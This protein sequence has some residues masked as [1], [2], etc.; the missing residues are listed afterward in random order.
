MHS[1][2]EAVSELRAFGADA[3][4]GPVTL[5]EGLEL[6]FPDFKEIVCVD[7]ALGE[8]VAVYVRAGADSSVYKH[9]SYVDSR[10]A[11]MPYRAYF[12]FV[13]AKISFTAEGHVQRSFLKALVGD[14]VH[15]ANHLLVRQMHLRIV[16][17]PAYR[18]DG[19]QSPLACSE[20]FEGG[21][22][23]F[24]FMDVPFVHACDHIGVQSVLG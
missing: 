11:E 21:M 2:A 22:D 14:K 20:R 12:L 24:Q 13:A 3:F 6:V 23:L 17:C 16:F 4:A 10:M 5:A 15:Q 18:D 8:D 19:E 7:V 9:G 1:S